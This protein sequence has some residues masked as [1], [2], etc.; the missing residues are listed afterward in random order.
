MGIFSDP[1]TFNDGTSDHIFNYRAQIP[2]S[3]SIVGEWIEPLSS[4]S[5][6][7][8]IL[9]KHTVTKAGTE[10]HLV[11]HSENVLLADGVTYEPVVVNL[12]VSHSPSHPEAALLLVEKRAVASFTDANLGNL[13]KGLI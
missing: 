9:I 5:V 13:V 3:N 4:S 10:R 12:S 11:Q 1:V 2:E 7:S 6:D 8:K